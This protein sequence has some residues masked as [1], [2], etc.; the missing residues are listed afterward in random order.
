VEKRG[1]AWGGGTSDYTAAPTDIRF[2]P[3][4]PDEASV[5]DVRIDKISGWGYGP[6]QRELL[7]G[8]WEFRISLR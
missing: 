1:S 3:R 2:S 4:P 6:V 7:S 8:P 5:I